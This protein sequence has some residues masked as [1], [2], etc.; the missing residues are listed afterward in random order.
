VSHEPEVAAAVYLA[1]ILDAAQRGRFE[2]HLLEC[3][4]CWR[5]V[6]TAHRGRALGE[7]LREVAPQPLRE[8]VRASV[9]AASR[10]DRRRRRRPKLAAAVVAAM[11][12][13]L[14]AGGILAGTR[15][16]DQPAVIAA[17]VAS[18][19]TGG[20]EGSVPSRARPSLPQAGGLRWRGARQG[21]L[22][23]LPVV[24]HDYRDAA[25]REL[26][27]LLA[28]RSFPEA[29]GAWHPPGAAIWVAEVEGV[30]VLCADRPSP[31]LLVGPDR[32]QVLLAASRLGLH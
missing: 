14:V 10:L 25:G 27:L 8:R 1:G 9:A 3:E 20:L 4:E 17:A 16:G 19:R 32:A 22:A 29:V 7:S 23:G 30:A 18:Y 11:V 2:E 13:A 6:R 21:R 5:E 28:D 26:T 31:S 24:A 15:P 12:L